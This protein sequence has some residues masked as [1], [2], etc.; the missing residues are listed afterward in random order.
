MELYSMTVS[1]AMSGR[2]R[3]REREHMREREEGGGQVR[4]EETEN[5]WATRNR[6]SERE[7]VSVCVLRVTSEDTES[8]QSHLNKRAREA[9]LTTGNSEE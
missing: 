6:A 1:A 7:R 4:A 2:A 8:L 3:A 9:E 5:G